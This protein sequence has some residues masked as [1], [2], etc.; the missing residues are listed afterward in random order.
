MRFTYKEIGIVTLKLK[1]QTD[2]ICQNGL[3]SDIV[4][5]TFVR[6]R[7]SDIQHGYDFVPSRIQKKRPETTNRLVSYLP[8]TT[9]NKIIT[10]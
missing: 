2:D 3:Q 10:G 8:G 5:M 1:E 9:R 7:F 4:E 6:S